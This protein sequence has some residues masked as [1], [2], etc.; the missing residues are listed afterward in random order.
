LLTTAL[1]TLFKD[2]QL[3]NYS[4]KKLNISIFD[5]LNAQIYVKTCCLKSLKSV[6]KVLVSISYKIKKVLLIGARGQTL[7]N[8]KKKGYANPCQKTLIKET[9]K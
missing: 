4:L 7:S 8:K 5:A 1:R 3:R 2:I 9:T 6:F